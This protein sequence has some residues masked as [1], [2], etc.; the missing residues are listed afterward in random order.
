MHEELTLATDTL[1]HRIA[2]WARTR[3][4]DPATHVQ[5]GGQW[6]TKSWSEYYQTITEVGRGLMTLGHNPGDAVALVG[7]NRPEWVESQFGITAIG[8]IP[9]PLYPTS[10]VEQM[11]YIINDCGAK[12]AIC[13]GREMLDKYLAAERDGHFPKLTNII[14]FDP[15][16]CDDPRVQSFEELRALGRVHAM[17]DYDARLGALSADDICLL[18]YTSGTTGR[19]KGVMQDHAGQL[20]C[21]QGVLAMFPI[22]RSE[23]PYRV[24]SYLPLCHQTEQVVTNVGGILTGGQ[25]WFCPEISQVRDYLAMA[26]PTLFMAVPRVWEKFEAAMRA[27]L[28]QATGV[29]AK[30]AEWARRTEL[31]GFDR[32]VIDGRFHGGLRRAVAR[33]LVID[34]VKR[35]LGLDA[36]AA[37]FTGAAPIG[38]DT[39]RFFASLGI[40]IHEAYGMSETS[41]VATV[42]PLGR[43]RLGTVGK[44]LDGV[45]VK[46]AEDGEILLKGRIMTRGYWNMPKETAALY[47]EGGFMRTGDLGELD[48]E[49]NLRITG[50]KKELLITAGGKNVAPVELEHLLRAIDGVGQAVV[51]GDGQ[52]FLCALLSLDPENLAGLRTAAGQPSATLAELA[53]DPAVRTH[54]ME[55]VDMGCNQRV[56]RYQTIKKIS[57]LSDEMSVEG[58]ELTPT[59]K[60]R[61]KEI[62]EKFADLI[63]SFYADKN[64]GTNDRRA[65]G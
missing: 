63:A 28:G 4:D 17:A 19:P 57:V 49:G 2:T 22:F 47:A 21:I 6:A 14:T 38:V 7:E 46:L 42:N 61:R 23:V 35:G 5:R 40:T 26:R 25:V 45:T 12:L 30:L 51:V 37:G 11:G 16:E 60:L 44:A 59:M 27:R 41:G 13:D 8:G 15:L 43:P 34:K 52:P 62:H 53:S 36:L 1:V 24:V 3:P 39:M 50:R 65:A 64:A 48:T 9:A 54:L 29:A 20:Q 58:G 56:A 10:T 33:K 31:A 55:Q 18:I 32:D